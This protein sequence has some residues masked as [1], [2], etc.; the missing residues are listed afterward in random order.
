MCGLL[1][2]ASLYCQLSVSLYNCGCGFCFFLASCSFVL[3]WRYIATVLCTVC[4]DSVAARTS[5][6][7]NA[8]SGVTYVVMVCRYLHMHSSLKVLYLAVLV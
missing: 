6:V 7:E 3:P 4:H 1:I 8:A 2:S 5:D